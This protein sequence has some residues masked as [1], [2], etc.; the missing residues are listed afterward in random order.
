MFDWDDISYQQIK[1]ALETN[2]KNPIYEFN[3]EI[4]EE[5]MKNPKV[6]FLYIGKN[7]KLKHFKKF[8]RRFEIQCAIITENLEVA[9]RLYEDHL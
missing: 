7:T 5:H 6:L 2:I 3:K 9:K 1:Q 4:F 8:C